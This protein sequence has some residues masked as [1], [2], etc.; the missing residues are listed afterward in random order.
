[1]DIRIGSSSNNNHLRATFLGPGQPINSDSCPALCNIGY[2]TVMRDSYAAGRSGVAPFRYISDDNAN[3]SV[4]DLAC[5]PCAFGDT[6][7][8][9]GACP[10]AFFRDRSIPLDITPGAC[11]PCTV[12][13]QCAT[14][15]FAPACDGNGTADVQC[16]P[17]SRDLLFQQPSASSSDDAGP[18]P[19]RVFV[20]YEASIAALTGLIRL[21]AGSGGGCPTACA[22]NRVLDPRDSTT[23]I[24]CDAFIAQQGCAAEETRLAGQYPPQQPQACAFR[25]AH[26]NATP[27]ALW[28]D[29]PQFTP[30]FLVNRL[31]T[32]VGGGGSSTP[33]LYMRGG[34]C[35][36]CPLGLGTVDTSTNL[37]EL[38][39]GY[40][41]VGQGLVAERAPIPTLSADLEIILEEPR[42]SFFLA[43][44]TPATGPQHQRMLRRRH[45][46]SLDP[47]PPPLLLLLPNNNHADNNASHDNHQRSLLLLQP[48]SA[49]SYGACLIGT[50]NTGRG[51]SVCNACPPG[52]TTYTR[53]SVGIHQC[54]CLYGFY[55][56]SRTQ[57]GGCVPC[58][59][60]TYDHRLTW[61]L[62]LP[63]LMMLT[64]QPGEQQMQQCLPCPSTETTFASNAQSSCACRPGALRVADTPNTTTTTATTTTDS[65]T[66][67]SVR[68]K[69]CVPCP[70]NHFCVPCFQGQPGCPNSLVWVTPC[71]PGGVSPPGST[72]LLNCTCSSNQSRLLRG[73]TTTITTTATLEEAL[74][75]LSSSSLSSTASP[76]LQRLA[77]PVNTGLYCLVRTTTTTS[78]ISLLLLRLL[79]NIII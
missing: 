46:L 71:M 5:V 37:C 70:A 75:L 18:D 10:P 33:P 79:L 69:R 15:H 55:N 2:H 50:Y 68:G 21:S 45:L 62:P 48:S 32:S 51:G 29:A 7:A 38:Q 73:P 59:V 41:L 64:Q 72:S 54:V 24:T 43:A 35:W 4:W 49:S 17:C 67:T 14:G 19:P 6:V 3:V 74:L 28:W 34:M 47:P 1:M 76:L 11:R 39:P 58:P 16:Q 20:P 8:C 53:G 42:P 78:I 23:C 63:T 12:S 52:T 66:S 9:H 61:Q 22:N 56:A 57:R 30:R 77:P 31:R 65:P 26:W 13:T 40:G 25:Y 60:D 36:A 44:A 27:A